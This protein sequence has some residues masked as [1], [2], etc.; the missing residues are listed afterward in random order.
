ME[1]S[2][3][4]ARYNRSTLMYPL[5]LECFKENYQTFYDCF[6]T[7][8]KE[9]FKRQFKGGG[10]ELFQKSAQDQS[11][12]D[13]HRR[14]HNYAEFMAMSMGSS[15]ETLSTLYSKREMSLEEYIYLPSHLTVN[16]RQEMEKKYG[17]AL[18]QR[19]DREFE[20]LA[21]R[22]AKQFEH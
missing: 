15:K 20:L 10:A 21:D 12:V 18:L 7:I 13:P 22:I 2:N 14:I 5:L 16:R 11:E 4:D 1:G 8:F 19:V 9:R 6:F 3:D 17:A